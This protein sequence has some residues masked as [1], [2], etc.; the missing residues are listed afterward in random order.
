MDGSEKQASPPAEYA[1]VYE[2]EEEKQLYGWLNLVQNLALLFAAL[3]GLSSFWGLRHIL[4]SESGFSGWL[5]SGA[6]AIVLAAMLAGAWHILFGVAVRRRLRG[7]VFSLLF[8]GGLILTAIQIATTSWFLATALGGSAALQVHQTAL[9]NDLSKVLTVLQG[10]AES[11]RSLLAAMNQASEGLRSYQ[12]CETAEGCISGTRGDGPVARNLE[13]SLRSLEGQQI[14]LEAALSR[15]P[16]LLS[17]VSAQIEAARIASLDGDERAFGTAVRAALSNLSAAQAAEPSR[18]LASLQSGSSYPETQAILA[19]LK[20]ALSSFTAIG[21]VPA[22]P[23]YQPMDRA[24]AVIEYSD[25]VSFAWVI[26]VVIDCLIFALLLLILLAAHLRLID[27]VPEQHIP[28]A[29]ETNSPPANP[30]QHVE[31]EANADPPPTKRYM[32]TLRLTDPRDQTPEK[33][34]AE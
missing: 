12:A 28:A 2:D 14:E 3:I 23:V 15:R 1:W 7:Q 27:P 25:E 26:A 5:I 13:R 32:G 4:E 10:R 24:S 8:L 17:E 20:G 33:I 18:V 31:K 29:P 21:S 30:E 34:P 16:A 9:L 19:R 22:L 6:L 11:E